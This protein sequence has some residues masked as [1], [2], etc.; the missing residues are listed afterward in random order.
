MKRRPRPPVPPQMA[1]R[2]NPNLVPQFEA[3]Q[4]TFKIDQD[5]SV[6]A[7][8]ID[9]AIEWMNDRAMAGWQLF[10]FNKLY[11]DGM[12]LIL[13]VMAR[14][15]ERKVTPVKTIIQAGEGEIP[16]KYEPRT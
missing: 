10:E 7:T 5:Q 4:F 15:V 6:S 11:Q 9:P 14:S 8:N 1:A 16:T 2:P 12:L 3:R 13:V